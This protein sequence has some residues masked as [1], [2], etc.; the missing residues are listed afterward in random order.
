MT[1]TVS[2]F[3]GQIL[4]AR[5]TAHAPECVP[6]FASFI[7]CRLAPRA[8]STGRDLSQSRKQ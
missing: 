1:T 3:G 7:P 2:R 8:R 5:M 4:R 6:P